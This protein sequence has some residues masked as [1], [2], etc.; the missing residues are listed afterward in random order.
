MGYCYA[1]SLLEL[2]GCQD[3]PC[4]PNRY[5]LK[6]VSEAHKGTGLETSSRDSTVAAHVDCQCIERFIC[7]FGVR[8]PVVVVVHYAHEDSGS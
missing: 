3:S 4:D 6:L 2:I 8:L 1:F 7:G 5:D